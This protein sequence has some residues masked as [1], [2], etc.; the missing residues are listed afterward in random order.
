MCTCVCLCINI[1]HSYRCSYIHILASYISKELFVQYSIQ[2]GDN[3]IQEG[4]PKYM[5][6]ELMQAQFGKPADIFRYG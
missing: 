3:D 6:P 2:L 4:D 5:A 1:Q